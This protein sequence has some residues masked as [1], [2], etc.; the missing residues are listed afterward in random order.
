MRRSI[1]LLG[2]AAIFA[3][4]VASATRAD[5]LPILTEDAGLT[6]IATNTGFRYVTIGERNLTVVAR[7]GPRQRVVAARFLP[8]RFTIPAVAYDGSPGGLSADGKTLV[9]IRPRVSFPQAQTSL[10]ILDARSFRVHRPLTLRGDFSYDAISPDGSTL[11]FI[12]YTSRTDPTRYAVRAFDV[13]SGKLIPGTIVDKSEP[14]EDMHGNPITRVTSPNGRWA[15][16]LYDGNGAKPFVHA[17]DT[18]GMQARCIDLD[19]LAGNRNLSNM[20]L[21]LD[22]G[23]LTVTSG[24]KAMLAVD[25]ATFR[26]GEPSAT[27]EGDDG[28]SP[29]IPVGGVGIAALLALGTVSLL[30]RRRRLATT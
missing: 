8:Q 5:G 27:S 28:V 26:V 29:W 7:I 19:A 10:V 25:T 1:M 9:L 2:V 21:R 23:T 18:V 14:D 3:G 4:A 13:A 15:Y 22:N 20:R 6:G 30:V 12:Q 11:Y 17:L 24:S 16:T